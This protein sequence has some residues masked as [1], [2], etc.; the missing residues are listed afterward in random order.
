MNNKTRWLIAASMVSAGA[1]M[2][3]KMA[4]NSNQPM[5]KVCRNAASMTS[6]AGHEAGDFISNM[7]DNLANRIR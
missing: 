6:K 4:R 5:K 1:V 7:G 2:G 3:I